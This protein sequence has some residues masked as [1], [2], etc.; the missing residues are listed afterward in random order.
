MEITKWIYLK[1]QPRGFPDNAKT[2]ILVQ[3]H[4]VAI[5]MLVT[6]LYAICQGETLTLTKIPQNWSQ[7]THSTLR[8]VGLSRDGVANPP[9]AGG[10]H[11]LITSK[12]GCT[13]YEYTTNLLAS[14]SQL[15]NS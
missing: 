12:L 3:W 5:K 4:T 7:P 9:E 11:L 14:G 8:K 6:Y 13:K 1:K 15:I 2:P 10:E